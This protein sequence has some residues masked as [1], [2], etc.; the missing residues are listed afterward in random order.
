MDR[1]S[2]RKQF[3]EK[4]NELGLKHTFDFDEAF[5]FVEYKR[6]CNDLTVPFELLP[7]EYTKEEF[8]EKIVELESRMIEHGSFVEED[9]NK[10]NPLV[11]SFADGCYI[12]QIYNPKGA[13]LV[14]KIHKVKHPFFL[15]KGDMSILSEEGEKRIKAPFYGITTAGTKRIIYCHEEC[16]FVTVHVTKETDLE[17]IENEIIA[18]SF[19]DIKCEVK[20]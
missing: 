19:D 2:A 12:R 11:H 5:D 15:L 1:E 3:D 17:K 4:T 14:T 10:M 8:R 18:K 20:I 16:V 13:I 6:L 9:V 7:A